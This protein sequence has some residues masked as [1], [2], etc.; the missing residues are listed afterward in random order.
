MEARAGGA[1]PQVRSRR[2]PQRTAHASGLC[3][4]RRKDEG[5]ERCESRKRG[6][7]AGGAAVNGQGMATTA[8]SADSSGGITNTR[9]VRR[10]V[11]AKFIGSSPSVGALA[12]AYC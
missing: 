3:R 2:E 9:A 5:G 4:C 1:Q 12:T 6:S 8:A 10:G 7:K 11:S